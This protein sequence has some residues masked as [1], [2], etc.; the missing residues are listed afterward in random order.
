MSTSVSKELFARVST[1]VKICYQTYGSPEHDP[2]ILVMGMSAQMTWWPESLCQKL[3]DAGFFVIRMDNRDAGRSDRF[4]TTQSITRN[5][6]VKA[7]FKLR[8]NP[9]YTLSD[10]ADD[11]I[12][13]LDHLG[14][15][16]VHAVGASMGGMIVQ[17][18]AIEHPERVRSFVS[19]MSTTGNR[20]VGWQSPRLIPRMLRPGAATKAEYVQQTLESVGVMGSPRFPE[21]PNSAADR[22]ELTWD[23]GL[24]GTGTMRQIM[25]ILSQPDRTRGLRMLRM[26]VG[27][28]HGSVDPLVHPSGGRATAAAVIGAEFDLIE[29]MG[30]DLPVELHDRFV[31]VIRHVANRA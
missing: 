28:I 19:M 10:M 4:E 22:A 8:R 26:P 18:M 20:T 15:E 21:D 5:D 7:F 3:V 17:T 6:I 29:G 25:A 11:V 13:L 31:S 30:H 9:P 16:S 27:V 1:G 2:L 24:S 12:G 14:L 23:R